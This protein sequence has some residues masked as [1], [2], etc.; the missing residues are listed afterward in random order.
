LVANVLENTPL[1][2]RFRRSLVHNKWNNWLNL[3]QRLMMV[4]LSVVLHKFVLKLTTTGVFLVILCNEVFMK[5]HARFLRKYCWKLRITLKI[6]T[7]MWF[8]SNKVLLTN[9]NLARC[10]WNGCT[11]CYFCSSLEAVEHLFP[12]DHQYVW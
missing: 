1:N 7:I 8:L 12:A 5:G 4:Q 10:N 9:D 2:I 11:K 3:C 6:K